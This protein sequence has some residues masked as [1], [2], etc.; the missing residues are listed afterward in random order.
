MS[1]PIPAGF[2]T[3]ASNI[4]DSPTL[5]NT[6]VECGIKAVHGNLSEIGSEIPSN[7]LSI[8]LPNGVLQ[9][10]H[11]AARGFR[12]VAARVFIKLCLV[13]S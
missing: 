5:S 1:T 2:H 11:V 4:I 7:G 6:G 9:S 12:S 10:N 8:Q 13:S 3:I